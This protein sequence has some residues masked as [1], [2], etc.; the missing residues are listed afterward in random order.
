MQDV[1]L[2]DGVEMP[3]LGLGVFQVTDLWRIRAIGV[4]TSSRIETHPFDQQVETQIFIE[5]YNVRIES[6]GPFAEGRNNIFQNVLLVPL[7][8]GHKKSV[9]QVILRSLTQRS[10][11]VIPKST[12]RQRIVENLDIFDFGLLPE[13]MKCSPQLIHWYPISITG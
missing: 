3:V 5:G 7:A 13:D 6:C 10:V 4:A 2:N 11:I 1:R 9:V 12:H 8:D